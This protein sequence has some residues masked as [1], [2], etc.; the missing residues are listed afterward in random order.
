[1]QTMMR[2][3][4][5]WRLAVMLLLV[6]G[7]RN[8]AAVA[9]SGKGGEYAVVDMQQVILNVSEG[10]QARANLEKEIKKKEKELLKRREELDQLNKEWKESAALLSEQARMKKQ[11]E[12]QQKFMQL[13]NDEMNFQSEIK[14][15]EQ[16]A[17][18]KI[19]VSVTKIVNKIAAERGF[20][21]VFETSSAG[22]LYLKN[23]VDLTDE[24][25]KVY[26]QQSKKKAD[27]TA[28]K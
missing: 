11:T 13:R 6:I 27:A 5:L 28:K 7:A 3:R 4:W 1:M 12:F 26:E 2:N 8:G 16:R 24:V 15:R 21:M 17:T 22:L 20:E 10:K 14:R 9:K 23:P 18:Q 25:I 19:A